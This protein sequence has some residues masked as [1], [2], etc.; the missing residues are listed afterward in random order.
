MRTFKLL[1]KEI[2]DEN[3]WGVQD[4]DAIKRGIVA[5]NFKGKTDDYD[6]DLKKGEEVYYQYGTQAKLDGEEYVLV[7]LTSLVCQ[8]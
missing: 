3:K 1:L 8:K 7:S 4:K 5:F 6:F 2:K